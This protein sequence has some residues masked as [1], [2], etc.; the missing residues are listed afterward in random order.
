MITGITQKLA[1]ISDKIAAVYGEIKTAIEKKISDFSNNLKKKLKSLFS[2]F[3][4]ENSDNEEKKIEDEKRV[5]ELKT[6]IHKIYEK[7]SRNKKDDIN[8]NEGN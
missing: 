4:T 1:D 8:V 6:F 5:F 2:I 3:G 7:I